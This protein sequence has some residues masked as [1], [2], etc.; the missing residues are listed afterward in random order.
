MAGMNFKKEHAEGAFQ[1]WPVLVWAA[2]NRQTLSYDDLSGPTRIYRRSLRTP[3]AVIKHYCEGKKSL[4]DYPLTVL[5]VNQ[6]TGKPGEGLDTVL[7]DDF[8]KARER[9]FAKARLKKKG[10]WEKAL[11]NPGLKTFYKL[12]EKLNKK[13]AKKK[14]RSKL[15]S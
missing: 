6:K 8:D 14:I 2:Q 4:K 9:V 3:L 12:I 13:N 5:V 10:D 11:S 15:S 1:I 7:D